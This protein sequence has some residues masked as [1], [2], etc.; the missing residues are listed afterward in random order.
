MPPRNLRL[1]LIVFA[2]TVMLYITAIHQRSHSAHEQRVVVN[3]H[4]SIPEQQKPLQEELPIVPEKFMTYYPHSG[5]HNQRIALV[6]A[7]VL[8][9]ALGRT[10]ILP[11]VNVGKGNYW[12]PTPKLPE[13]MDHCLSL[14]VRERRGYC[15]EY[16]QYVGA[17]VADIFD[18]SGARAAGIKMI[19]RRNMSIDYFEKYWGAQPSD[20]AQIVDDSRFSYCIYDNA[21]S[22]EPLQHQFQRRI[23]LEDLAQQQEPFLVFGSLF[24]TFRLHLEDERLVQLRDFLEAE[25]GFGHPVVLEQALAIV[26]R[27]GGPGTF[28]SVHVRV[29]DGVFST[30]V[31]DTVARVQHNLRR[32]VQTTEKMEKYKQGGHFDKLLYECVASKSPII[33]MAT[34]AAKP[35]ETLAELYMEF[36]C[37]FTISDFPEVIQNIVTSAT[38][39]YGPLLLPFV[40]AEVS[41]HGSFFVGT[42]K[43]TFSKYIQTRNHRFL[44][45]YPHATSTD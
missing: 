10:L 5:F 31:Q 32:Q 30:M 45:L 20:I 40:D 41:S 3:V 27:L 9:K 34:D 15:K 7:M 23:N 6:N 26:S 14:P 17:A 21:S 25:T 12:W 19:Q 1:V 4:Q 24:S 39:A 28:T 29:G 16:Q 13:K 22:T 42:R 18:L 44:T 33:Y 43:S 36:P 8:A 38:D 37:L 2:S 11:E 35:R